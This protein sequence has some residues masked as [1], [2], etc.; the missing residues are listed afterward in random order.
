MVPL[1]YD[2]LCAE[3]ETRTRAVIAVVEHADLTA[4]VPSCPG[5]DLGHL[6]QHIGGVHRWMAEIVG[7]RATAP[8]DGEFV[9]DPTASRIDPG[10]LVPWLHD[11]AAKLT[12]TLR[13]ADPD[14]AVWSPGPA[15]TPRF[16]AR[17]AMLETA[18]HGCDAAEAVGADMQLPPELAADGFEEWLDNASVPEAYE[19]RPDLPDLLGPGRGLVF[20][21]TETFGTAGPTVVPTSPNVA[22]PAS[23]AATSSA[24]SPDS[25][26]TG[27]A[28][29]N[30]AE[31]VGVTGDIGSWVVDLG[32]QAATWR[33]GTGPGSVWVGGAVA[34]LLLYVYRRPHGAL[35]LTGDIELLELWRTRAGFW[36]NA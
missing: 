18:L 25:D 35:R 20:D 8:I 1:T 12:A 34:D 4:S 36:L 7:T 10:E 15:G 28:P 26:P 11:G 32:G 33:R 29:S 5:W 23:T 14:I 6:L 24:T 27:T 17:R 31:P 30:T 21:A 9:D 16:W 19:S 22:D 3:I 13:A 2:R